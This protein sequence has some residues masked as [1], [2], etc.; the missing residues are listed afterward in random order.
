MMYFVITSWSLPKRK[1][2]SYWQHY[3][4]GMSYTSSYDEAARTFASS[5]HGLDRGIE[6]RN[7]FTDEKKNYILHRDGLLTT[8]AGKVVI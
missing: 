2:G 7:A 8:K 5:Q 6:V 3:F 4:K 1:L